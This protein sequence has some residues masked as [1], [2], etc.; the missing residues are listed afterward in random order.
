M[1]C[2]HCRSTRI[3]VTNTNDYRDGKE[4]RRRRKCLACDHRW[5]TLEI[6]EALLRRTPPTTNS[7]TTAR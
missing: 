4:I 1:L 7:T 3:T 5:T 6:Y 2:P